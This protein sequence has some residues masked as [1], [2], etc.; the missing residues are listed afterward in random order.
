MH[1]S[2]DRA[3]Y[4]VRDADKVCVDTKPT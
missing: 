2:N 1:T 3:H 4:R